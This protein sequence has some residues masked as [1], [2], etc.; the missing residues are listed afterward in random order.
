MNN[1]VMKDES[2]QNALYEE[3][4]GRKKKQKWEVTWG[5]RSQRDNEH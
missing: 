4:N 3:E 2:D 5:E 1:K